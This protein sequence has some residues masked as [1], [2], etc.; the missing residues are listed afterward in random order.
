MAAT[1][2]PRV[3]LST[4]EA[5]SADELIIELVADNPAKTTLQISNPTK[6][7]IIYTIKSNASHYLARPCQGLIGAGDN[8]IV[9]I[10]FRDAQ[11]QAILAEAVDGPIVCNDIV[12]VVT[13]SVVADLA[14]VI[15]TTKGKKLKALISRIFAQEDKFPSRWTTLSV[16]LVVP[17]KD[18]TSPRPAKKQR[19]SA[20]PSEVS[21]TTTSRAGS[22]LPPTA[23][24]SSSDSDDEGQDLSLASTR[25]PG[26]RIYSFDEVDDL[27]GNNL[28]EADATAF[29]AAWRGAVKITTQGVVH[30]LGTVAL[31]ALTRGSQLLDAS[32]P[33]SLEAPN[34]EH[35][36]RCIAVAAGHKVYHFLL[37]T[38][39]DDDDAVKTRAASYYI[40]SARNVPP[41]AA[42]FVRHGGVDESTILGVVVLRDIILGEELRLRHDALPAKQ[43]SS[44]DDVADSSSEE[45]DDNN[46]SRINWEGTWDLRSVRAVEAL[47]VERLRELCGDQGLPVQKG[48]RAAKEMAKR[49]FEHMRSR[50]MP[51][52]PVAPIDPNNVSQINYTGIWSLPS[53]KRIEALGV[54]RL[55]KLCEDRDLTALKG[56]GA[57]RKMSR[58]LFEHFKTHTMP[59]YKAPPPVPRPQ[60]VLKKSAQVAARI[61]KVVVQHSGDTLTLGRAFIPTANPRERIQMIED[62]SKEVQ[63]IRSEA[64]GL[65]ETPD[66]DAEGLDTQGEVMLAT[67]HAGPLIVT[68]AVGGIGKKPLTDLCLHVHKVLESGGPLFSKELPSGYTE[69]LGG[70]RDIAPRGDRGGFR[71]GYVSHESLAET[72]G[73]RRTGAI[74]EYDASQVTAL[75]RYARRL[76]RD[77]QDPT[78]ETTVEND[79]RGALLLRF[80][81]VANRDDS[82]AAGKFTVVPATP[83]QVRDKIRAMEAEVAKDGQ[84]LELL[85]PKEYLNSQYHKLWLTDTSKTDSTG[86]PITNNGVYLVSY[87]AYGPQRLGILLRDL[88]FAF[89]MDQ[90]TVAFEMDRVTDQGTKDRDEFTETRKWV[91]KLIVRNVFAGKKP[92]EMDGVA[93]TWRNKMERTMIINY[94]MM[95][96]FKAPNT[97]FKRRHTSHRLS[98]VQNGDCLTSYS[99]GTDHAYNWLKPYWLQGTADDPELPRTFMSEQA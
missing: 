44:D 78:K 33:V 11:K 70:H 49:L 15:E 35:A 65:D 16:T 79:R 67:R 80:L 4:P 18:N 93:Q 55:Q 30:G 74:V 40:N 10:E 51:G 95:I 61:S 23:G 26:P 72:A 98:L 45:E 60:R 14:K 85:T 43:E 89:E 37:D 46:R 19:Q 92:W 28:S 90:V 88:Q 71:V 5:S 12:W 53:A 22:A 39:D 31:R 84:T 36:H 42:F 73:S 41:N 20:Q 97:R 32:A 29:R 38:L 9:E 77:A 59:V 7:S 87:D 48:G 3:H 27:G 86:Q 69:A 81:T 83:D 82:D 75:I 64:T 76:L 57:A 17:Q 91:R 99:R 54:P 56:D 47:G 6:D 58:A 34:P 62:F 63:R 21:S 8:Q 2:G 50:P 52:A 66:S 96:H 68:A 24:G 1:T 13:T 25:P 94:N